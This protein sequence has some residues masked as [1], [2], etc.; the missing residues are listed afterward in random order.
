MKI[1]LTGAT[2]L[3]GK[4]LTSLLLEK[5]H[6]IHYLTTSKDKLE[7]LSNYQGFYWNPEK[8][9]IDERCLKEVDVIVHLAGANI[10]KC[11][12]N[13]YK[14]EILESRIVSLQ[15]LF[16]LV[17]TTKNQVRQ[18]ISASATAIY[19]DSFSKIYDENTLEIKDGFL[20]NVVVKWEEGATV[21]NELGIKVCKL[22][23]GVVL[24]S[25]G[26]VLSEL[27]RPIRIGIGTIMGSGKQIQSWIHIND[28]VAMYYFAIEM[29]L[30][31]VF[32]AVA[33]NPVSHKEMTKVLAKV[34]RKPLLLPNIPKFFIQI[35]L[36]EMSSLLFFSENISC[37]K[38]INLGFQF[39]F[40]TIEKA[41]TDLYK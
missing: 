39:Q 26:G 8:G 20:S 24:S 9:I 22:R 21:F 25:K 28:L 19:P 3:I 40:S 29:Q 34:L 1:L 37:Q 36:G 30:D 35:F 33:P 15:V 17:K 5:K 27:A 41:I 12:T 23:T 38:I 16:N 32:N 10:A 2:G 31:G 13:A 18:I 6:S 4:E 14:K 11:W 7:N